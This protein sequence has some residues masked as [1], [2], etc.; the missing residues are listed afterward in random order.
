MGAELPPGAPPPRRPTSLWAVGSLLCGLGLFCPPVLLVAPLL[1]LRAL[2]EIRARPELGG[3][4]R[5]L[6]W[7]GIIL[8][9]IGTAA[10]AGAAAWWQVNVRRPILEG[11]SAALSAG[12]DG[13]IPAFRAAFDQSGGSGTGGDLEAAAF[14]ANLRQRYGRFIQASQAPAPPADGPPPPVETGTKAPGAA[15]ATDR[16]RLRIGY[17][18]VFEKQEVDAEAEFILVAKGAPGLVLRFGWIVV[19]DRERGDL[20]YPSS[21][22]E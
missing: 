1:G 19:H 17:R 21:D 13:D 22:G 9:V 8:G 16:S 18:I 6:A 10:W 3:R 5:R 20:A 2:V 15:A 11:P 7:A 4:G 14:I 12:F